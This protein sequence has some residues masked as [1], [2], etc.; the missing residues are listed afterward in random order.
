MSLGSVGGI[1]PGAAGSPAAQI[2]GSDVE[3]AQLATANQRRANAAARLAASATGIGETDGHDLETG[4]RDADGR[5]PWEI[6]QDPHK[7]DSDPPPLKPRVAG[8]DGPRGGTLDVT[9]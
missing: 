6:R 1:G 4:D 8:D 9:A 7:N 3:R 5:R 2:T